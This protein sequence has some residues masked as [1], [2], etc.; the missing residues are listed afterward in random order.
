M[1]LN[2]SITSSARTRNDSGIVSTHRLRGLHVYDQLEL[3]RRLHRKIGRLCPAQNTVELRRG[4]P[5]RIA[6]NVSVRDEAATFGEIF[7]REVTLEQFDLRSF[8]FNIGHI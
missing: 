6:D 2:H 1:G 4:L 7:E 8:T 3:D 5:I